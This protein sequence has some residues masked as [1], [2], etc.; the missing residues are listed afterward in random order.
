MPREMEK[1]TKDHWSETWETEGPCQR[2]LR[3]RV[4]RHLALNKRMGLLFKKYLVPSNKKLLDIGC[5]NGKWLVYFQQELGFEVYGVDYSERGCE[6][7]KETLRRNKAEGEI[8][9]A[10][11]FDNTF[12]S[13]YEEYFDTV[14]SM[15]VVEHFDDPTDVIHIHLKLLKRGGNLIITI[16]NF[17]DG[18]LYR[19]AQKMFG[20]EEE[21]LRG[22]NVA[23][24]KMPNFRN[25]VE[26]FTNLE[27]EML[28]YVGPLSIVNIIPWRFGLQYTLYPLNELIGYA[29]FFLNSETFSPVVAFIGRK[30]K[31]V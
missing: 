16:P 18:S 15:G 28:D 23:L 24:M 13:Q 14:L 20:H 31:G 1:I 27:I 11:I 12:Q 5:G 4:F 22:H 3:H 7:A 9:C 26:G 8:I 25:Y 2:F 17:G 21:L 29:T 30:R 19:K 6:I 10:D